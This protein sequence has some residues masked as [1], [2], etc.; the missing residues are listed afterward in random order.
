ML[1]TCVIANNGA[2]N[3]L[4]DRVPEERRIHTGRHK[5]ANQMATWQPQLVDQCTRAH[6]LGTDAIHLH[7]GGQWIDN[8]HI[9]RNN[10]G[11]EFSKLPKSVRKHHVV[12]LIHMLI[13][14]NNALK[15]R[16]LVTHTSLIERP[17]M[18]RGRW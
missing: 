15:S 1:C 7:R 12:I 16:E 4:I 14:K 3:R 11:P 10:I 13:S 6:P 8:R 9:A 2:T 17:T 18:K 5:C